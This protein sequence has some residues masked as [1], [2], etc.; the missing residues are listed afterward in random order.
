[1]PLGF[2]EI[3]S[4]SS[5]IK[6]GKFTPYSLTVDKRTKKTLSVDN[7]LLRMS[8]YCAYAERSIDEVKKKL[9]TIGVSPND[10]ELVMERL[11]KQGFLNEDRFASAF[12]GGKFRIKKWGKK[13]IG[14]EM[15][16]KGLTDDLIEKELSLLP[17]KEY[18]ETLDMLLQKKWKQIMRGDTGETDYDTQQKNKGK[19]IRYALQKGYE[20]DLVLEKVRKMGI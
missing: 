20:M 7:A 5:A 18:Q 17:E 6:S 9:K 2:A 12:A 10:S 4:L 11:K 16:R 15:K 14:M 3:F 13:R 8:K 1:M 19:L